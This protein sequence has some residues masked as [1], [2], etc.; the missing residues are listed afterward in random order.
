MPERAT[1]RRGR[2]R[3]DNFPTD[4]VTK[5]VTFGITALLPGQPSK[6]KN[7]CAPR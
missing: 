3:T 5:R 7:D 2:W 6:S 1:V 4:N